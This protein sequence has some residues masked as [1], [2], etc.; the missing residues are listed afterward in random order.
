MANCLKSVSFGA[1]CW[2]GRMAASDIVAT[3]PSISSKH[4]C[5][6]V[7]RFE[8]K[9][10]TNESVDLALS[11]NSSYSEKEENHVSKKFVLKCKITDHSSNGTWISNKKSRR[12]CRLKYQE[13][14]EIKVGDIIYLLSPSHSQSYLFKY[15]L[16]KGI[17]NGEFV[18]CQSP[19]EMSEANTKEL[20]TKRTSS[21]R[22]MPLSKK[23]K[24][25]VVDKKEESAS[26]KLP[27][28]P[29]GEQEQCP[30]CLDNFDLNELVDHVELCQQNSTDK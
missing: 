25:E 3:H 10:E 15:I 29:S 11:Q 27:S 18:I 22:V 21:E 30:H 4:C 2:I 26:P 7:E 23:V 17:K 13:P 5:L 6:L 24:T 8:K 9:P 28:L 12:I 1:C 16:C 20:L 14:T 19:I